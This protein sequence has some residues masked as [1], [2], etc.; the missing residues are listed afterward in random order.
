MDEDLAIGRRVR[1]ARDALNLTQE[2]LAERA[3]L[4]VGVVKK[5]ERGGT[6]RIDTYHALASAL[7]LRTS[8]LFDPPALGADPHAD[9]RTM[10]LMPLRQAISPPVTI[11]G[12]LSL[13]DADEPVALDRLRR[14]ADSVVGS[15]YQDD[16]D[17]LGKLLPPLVQAA[18][19][20]VDRFDDGDDRAA[21]LE[22][23]ADV[24][25]MAG[26]YLTAVRAYD[27]A[28]I[29]LRDAVR[30]AAA[31]EDRARGAAG[32]Y[33][34]GWMLLRQGRLDE[35]ELI[36]VAT[37][38]EVEP[39]ISRASRGELGVWGRLLLRGSSAAARNNR[40]GEAREMLRV[41][42]TAALALGG[43]TATEMRSWG[44]FDWSSVALQAIEN[45]SVARRPERVLGLARRLPPTLTLTSNTRNRHLLDVAHAH[46]QLRQADDA[47]R[48]LSALRNST[49]GWL[50]HQGLARDVFRAARRAKRRPLTW[51]Q[52][53]VGEFLR[54]R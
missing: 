30:D 40:P 48:I 36:S 28:H 46:T 38:D 34:Q 8:Q 52:R 51:E 49:P 17:E 7:G 37:A 41:A 3:G 13:T 5:I 11:G 33:L 35:T 53:E 10:A 45:H 42:R 23:R 14:A 21:A 16:Y 26:R 27:L 12:R 25:L 9:D 19:L 6:C 4:S 15:Y 47:F 29:A 32:V 22:L 24:L 54:V 2:Q 1:R 39:R 50:Q 31:V 43:R 20:A 44:R 18:H